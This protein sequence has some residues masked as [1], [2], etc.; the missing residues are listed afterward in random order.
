M[1][2]ETKT[3]ISPIAIDL[4]AKNTG[5]YFAHYKAGSSPD[6]ID[7]KGKVYQLEKD[8]YT[9]LMA[10]RTAA[11]HQRRGYDRRQMAK[12][13]FK[14]IWEKHFKLRWDKDVQQTISF[15]LNRRGFSFLTEEYDTKVLSR[16]PQE[17]YKLLPKELQID[18]NEN[19]EYDFDA[20][21]VGWAQEEKAVDK[22]KE[23][24]DAINR[25]LKQI[26]QRREFINSTK[27][28][29]KYCQKC[30]KG[31]KAKIKLNELSRFTLEEWHQKNVQGLPPASSDRKIGLVEYLNKQNSKVAQVIL[32]SLPDVSE[33]ERKLKKSYW[34]FKVENFN[35]SDADF[36]QSE[37]TERSRE[38]LKTHLN[39]LAFALY[40]TLV[41]LQSGGRHRSNY[42]KEVKTVLENKNHRHK[43]LERFCEELRAKK[44]K[45]LD[46]DSL[47]NLIGHI[48][49]LEL[50]PLRKY[51]ND[52]EHK[53]SVTNKQ[54][55]RW[56]EDRITELFERWILHEWRVNPQKD[57]QK[58]A[59][60]EYDY[61]TLRTKWKEKNDGLIGFWLQT[62]PG[63]T[64]PPYQDNNNR[65]PPKCQSLIFNV[66]FLDDK[67]PTWQDWLAELKKLQFVKTYL[68]DYEEELRKLKSG[69]GKSYFNKDADYKGSLLK[70]SG[71]RSEEELDARILQFIFDRVKAEDEL[72]LNEIYSHAK[73]Y[74][75]LKSAEEEKQIA[76]DKLEEAKGKLEQAI[77]EKRLAW[78][79]ENPKK[80]RKRSI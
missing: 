49:N 18:P 56:K 71:R 59:G 67:Y 53:I 48:S 28:L 16:F 42:F 65:R 57:K 15:L 38:W 9:L 1:T 31:E 79:T 54:G 30:V 14:L 76:K 32:D 36:T 13:L 77:K 37:N 43:Y 17:A 50:K 73:K 24:F 8:K 70:D 5:V 10:K 61:K 23:K 41:E 27:E 80:L 46:I 55:D 66:H 20:A 12:R 78:R 2:E 51:F 39:H 3:I 45:G 64:I 47:S 52:P 19:D 44:Y 60:A 75:Q 21:L 58:A 35:Q 33:E 6:Q 72:R 26:E 74:R 62:D 4:G 7:K 34:N 11:R 25:E 68:G 63:S 69:K 29:K 22:I 40:K